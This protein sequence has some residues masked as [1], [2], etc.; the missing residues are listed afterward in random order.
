MIPGLPVIDV[1]LTTQFI[2][3]L[4]L[5]VILVAV[6]RLA[7]SRELMGAYANGRLY[8]AAAWLIVAVVSA[9]SAVLVVKTALG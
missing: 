9:L 8:N 1:L 6:L 3:G 7:G 2:N 5:P 4:L